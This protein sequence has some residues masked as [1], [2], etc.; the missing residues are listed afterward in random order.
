MSRFSTPDEI[1]GPVSIKKLKDDDKYERITKGYLPEAEVVFLDEIWKAGP[2]I[3]NTLLTILNEKI[4]RNGENEI[5]V[6][7]KAL[8]SASNELPAK[9]QGLEALWDRFLVRLFVNGIEDTKK[10]DGMIA[11]PLARK[12]DKS[13]EDKSF[14]GITGD[15]YKQWGKE[16]DNIAIPENVFNVIHVIRN[17]IEQHNQTEGNA[18][19]QIYV[20]DRRWRKI[21]RLLRTSAFLNDRTEVDLMDCFLIRHCIWNSDTQIQTVSVFVHEAVVKYGYTVPLDFD[22]I[23]EELAEFQT[24]IDE[25]TK[26]VKDIRVEALA[27]VHN[28]Y[29]EILNPLSQ[30]DNLIN[31]NEFNSLTNQNQVLYLCY[32]D[33]SYRQSQ[34]HNRYYMRKGNSKFSV[35]ISDIEYKLKTVIKGD[36]R[37]ATKKPHPAVEKTWDERTAGFLQHTGDMKA[38]IKQRRNKD[39]EHLRTNLFVKPELANIVETHITSTL[40][41]IEKIELDIREIQYGYKK[42]KEEEVIIDEEEEEEEFNDE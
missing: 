30:Y 13:D 34:H 3:Q 22:D 25:E 19:N 28:D 5:A 15:E 8:I 7:M 29:Y 18:E 20:S 26:F 27:S 6:P 21:V 10:F 11:M 24:E 14:D 41:D 2:S 9:D 37:Q 4:F 23:R 32:W 36:K 17:Y 42:L 35:F 39:L 1:F 38:Q 40:K 33:D 31:Q 16:I 12:E